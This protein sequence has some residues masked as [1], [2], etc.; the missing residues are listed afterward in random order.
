LETRLILYLLHKLTGPRGR[1]FYAQRRYDLR[2]VVNN[3]AR[4]QSGHVPSAVNL[5]PH[6]YASTALQPDTSAQLVF[7]CS[8]PL[9]RNAP[10]ATR[11]ALGMGYNNVC[12]MSAGI[13]GWLDAGLPAEQGM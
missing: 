12:V 13:K 3:A 10:Q 5:D 8:S 1:F 11:R 7:Y 6:H 2:I 9:C 4:W